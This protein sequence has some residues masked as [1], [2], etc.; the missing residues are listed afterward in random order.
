MVVMP[1]IQGHGR[2]QEVVRVERWF[3]FFMKVE[4]E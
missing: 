2:D 4:R 1:G 3:F